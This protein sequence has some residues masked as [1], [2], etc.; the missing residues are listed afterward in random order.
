MATPILDSKCER[1]VVSSHMVNGMVQ[2]ASIEVLSVS[3]D[4][5]AIK[6]AS[7]QSRLAKY[8]LIKID[9]WIHLRHTMLM[10]VAAMEILAFHYIM[11]HFLFL[12]LDTT[13]RYTV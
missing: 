4:G 9:R 8:I 12:Q 11:T 5:L 1:I 3:C 7:P 6:A 10:A 2:C 13:I